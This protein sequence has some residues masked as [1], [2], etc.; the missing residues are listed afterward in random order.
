[1]AVGDAH[2]FPGFLKPVV[3]QLPFESDQLLFSHAS[4]EMSGKNTPKRTHNRV[5]NSQA[6]GHESDTLTTELPGGLSVWFLIFIHIL[7]WIRIRDSH[8]VD[9][10][11]ISELKWAWHFLIESG[12]I[13]TTL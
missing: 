8:N 4:A 2:V 1:M 9:W 12:S 5:S 13:W 6:P 7:L 10:I 11:R 3:T